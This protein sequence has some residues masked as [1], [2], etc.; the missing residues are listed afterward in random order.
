MRGSELGAEAFELL[1]SYLF[2]ATPSI[3]ESATTTAMAE[4]H[5]TSPGRRF[6][7]GDGGV[8]RTTLVDLNCFLKRRC[9]ESVRTYY[10][11]SQVGQTGWNRA[12]LLKL[13]LIHI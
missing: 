5:P 8:A 11:L 9:C 6:V 13:S 4:D 12:K 7:R 1:A 3:S 2:G 10:V